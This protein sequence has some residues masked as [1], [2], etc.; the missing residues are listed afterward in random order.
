MKKLVLLVA[1][2]AAV[3]LAV[4]AFA[5]DIVAMP[6]GN[7]MG[8]RTVELNYINWRNFSPAG[9]DANIFEAFVGVTDY[10]ELDVLHFD[11]TGGGDSVTEA[12]AYLRLIKESPKHPSLIIGATNILGSDWVMGSDE[13]SPFILGAYNISC[14]AGRPSFNDPLVR[15]HLAWGDKFHG[16]RWFGGFQ[17]LFTPRFGAAAFNYQGEPSYVGVYTVSKALELRAGWKSGTPFYSAG[18]D[19]G[20]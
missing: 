19:F 14:P 15:M 20:F 3:G 7:M 16:D 2:I 17:F 18:L 9:D 5:G 12:N 1:L 13:V 10:L 4:P 6:T 8:A 11:P